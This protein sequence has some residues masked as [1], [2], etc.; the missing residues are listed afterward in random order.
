MQ[1]EKLFEAKSLVI[2][3][4]AQHQ[5]LYANWKGFQTVDSI[6]IGC[7]KMLEILK[8]KECKKVL[9]DNRLV[10]GP[11]QSAADWVATDWFPRMYA[12]GLAQLSWIVSPNVFSELSTEATQSKNKTDKTRTFKDYDAAEKWLIGK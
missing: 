8:Q 9:N 6:K 12:A 10:T 11:W 5:Y 7:E 1:K 3:F 4:D 2:E